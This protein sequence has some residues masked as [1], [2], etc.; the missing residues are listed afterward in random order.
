M[1]TIVIRIAFAA[2]L[3]T[4]GACTASMSS[5]K[6]HDSNPGELEGLMYFLPKKDIVVTVTI[7]KE[8]PPVLEIATTPAYP[9]VEHD[10][11]LSYNGSV[12]GKNKLSVVVSDNGLLNSATSTATSE[13]GI[14]L[15]KLATAVAE[16]TPIPAAEAE[17]AELCS[18]PG[19]YV[20]HFDAAEVIRAAGPCGSVVTIEKLGFSN[21]LRGT[22]DHGSDQGP[23][24]HYR[25]QLPYRVTLIGRQGAANHQVVAVVLSPSESGV[26]FLPVEKTLFAT[27][28]ATLEFNDG[29]PTKYEQE[30]SGEITAFLALPAE[31]IGAYF[32]AI[33]EILR[34]DK[35]LLTA[36]N[37]LRAAELELSVA[38]HKRELCLS[39]ISS[40]DS[41]KIE[42]LCG[43]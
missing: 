35:E 26:R 42:E 29:V 12:V 21:S 13:I 27:N 16:S 15:E 30:V 17:E 24:Y 2:L 37:E 7:A 32:S 22:V 20:D 36:E 41:K 31:V 4:V 6:V 11:Y 28:T 5:S 18:E 19:T 25:S 39:A 40:E 14:T 3:M 10:Y 33:G 23:G 43:D 8:K 38:N 34:R 9:D 1:H